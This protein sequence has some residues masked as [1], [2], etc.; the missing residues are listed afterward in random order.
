MLLSFLYL[1]W[2]NLPLISYTAAPYHIL[3]PSFSSAGIFSFWIV[4]YSASF[5][6]VAVVCPFHMAAFQLGIFFLSLHC[7]LLEISWALVSVLWQA[8]SAY[9]FVSDLL[10]DCI[11]SEQ[12]IDIIWRL[13][14]SSLAVLT[15]KMHFS[16]VKSFSQ[17]SLHSCK[18][19]HPTAQTV[20]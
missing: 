7:I 13:S 11:C 12:V 17:L 5:V 3:T 2:I 16:R 6:R 1:A 9:Y 10:L 19:R 8:S 4:T 18:V 14:P 15:P 20:N